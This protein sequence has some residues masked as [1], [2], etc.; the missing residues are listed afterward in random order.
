MSSELCLKLECMN[1]K[2][3]ESEDVIKKHLVRVTETQLRLID[4]I[5]EEVLPKLES[6]H[7][8]VLKKPEY[9][10]IGQVALL[11]GVSE[12]TIRNRI[13]EGN[14]PATKNEGERSYKIPRLEYYETRTE[15]KSKTNYRNVS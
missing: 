8:Q 3:V 7:N 5:H 11:E 1:Y 15:V 6:I 14:I 13:K 4:I 10:S 9:L 2:Y 12:K